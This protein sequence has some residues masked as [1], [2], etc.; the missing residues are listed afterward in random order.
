[1]A[2]RLEPSADL[3]LAKFKLICNWYDSDDIRSCFLCIYLL[4]L[5]SA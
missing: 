2:K 4:F 3:M 1:M 5:I